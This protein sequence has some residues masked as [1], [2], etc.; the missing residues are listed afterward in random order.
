VRPLLGNGARSACEAARLRASLALD[1]ELDEIH[2]LLLRRHLDRCPECADVV[3]EIR[4]VTAAV[5]RTPLELPPLAR[6]PVRLPPRR[7]PWATI[8]VAV[9]TLAVAALTLPELPASSG[10]RDAVPRLAAAPPR[11]PIGQRSALDD[12]LVAGRASSRQSG[13]ADGST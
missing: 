11:L 8:G 13:A 2:L 7:L 5:R 9:A 12:F 3:P 1:G 4:A 6:V 10:S